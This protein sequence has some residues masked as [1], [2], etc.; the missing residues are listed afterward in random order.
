MKLDKRIHKKAV[1]T[2]LNVLKLRMNKLYKL[3]CAQFEA[4]N[5]FLNDRL[6]TKQAEFNKEEDALLDKIKT[7][8]G[9]LTRAEET[10]ASQNGLIDDLEGEV[11]KLQGVKPRPLECRNCRKLEDA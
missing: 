1:T 10:I 7:L 8:E 5:S 11:C 4:A 3:R 9:Q 2:K 6:R